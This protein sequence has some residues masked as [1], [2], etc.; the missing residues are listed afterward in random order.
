MDH[1]SPFANTSGKV[2]F[3]YRGPLGAWGSTPEK[4]SFEG[5]EKLSSPDF[6]FIGV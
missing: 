6:A 5:S 2:D 1:L 4:N 3:L